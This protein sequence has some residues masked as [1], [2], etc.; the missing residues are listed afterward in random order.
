MSDVHTSAAT[1]MLEAALK[2]ADY[3]TEYTFGRLNE[4]ASRD[5]RTDR[6]ILA[7]VSRILRKHHDRVL[8]SIRGIGY[9][10]VH[11]SEAAGV[12]MSYQKAARKKIEVAY[13]VLDTVSPQQ[14]KDMSE[15][16]KNKFFTQQARAG[17]MLAV[18]KAVDS[19][20]FKKLAGINEH[21]IPKDR[22]VLGLI[23]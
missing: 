18:V 2:S 7:T 21:K 3:G 10:I 6:Y 14:L 16:D 12:S 5:V 15:A 19:R 4:I 20:R 17:T 9:R 13:E 23:T 8:Q 1:K 11:P 22:D